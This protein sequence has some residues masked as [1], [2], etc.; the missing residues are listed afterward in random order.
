MVGERELAG[1]LAAAQPA[2]DRLRRFRGGRKQSDATNA[3][4]AASR[5]TASIDRNL[6]RPTP[7]IRDR[8]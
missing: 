8:P 4:R 5:Q 1:L 6:L 3:S 7:A 2:V